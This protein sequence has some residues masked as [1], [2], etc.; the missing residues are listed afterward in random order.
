MKKGKTISTFFIIWSGQLLSIIGTSITNFGLGVWV[1]KLTGSVTQLALI[2]FSTTLPVLLLLPFSGSLVD[3][4]DRRTVMI[5][6][7]TV[8]G[9]S[10]LVIAILIFTNSFQ[11]WHIY[12]TT[13]ISSAASN[14]QSSAYSAS[15][16]LL[17]PK[18]QLG[19]ING[20]VQFSQALGYI[21]GPVLGALFLS[22][23]EIKGILI[24]DF[25]TFL[26]AVGAL[27]LVKIPL[28]FSI[29]ELKKKKQSLWMDAKEGIRYLLNKKG[30]IGLLGLYAALNFSGGIATVLMTPLVLSVADNMVLGSVMSVSGIGMVIGSVIMTAWGGPQRKMFGVLGFMAAIGLSIICFGIRPLVPLFF[31]AG[32]CAFFSIPIMNGCFTTLWQR[33]IAPEIQGR[34]F[35]LAGIVAVGTLPIAHLVAGPLADLIFEPALQTNGILAPSIGR[36]IGTGAGR[37]IGLMY[38]LLG[39]LSVIITCIGILTPRIRRLDLDLPDELKDDELP[40]EIE[41]KDIPIKE[42]A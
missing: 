16:P 11:I 28:P 23:I 36:I 18:K 38:I 29:E 15:I 34:A 31:C 14:F 9:I 17:V 7:D 41:K 40:E 19:R 39:L 42:N 5:V 12:I 24:I 37:G 30:L 25:A 6:G 20:I 32:F 3:R 33:K 10:T 22:L 26:F 1:Y 35:S 13:A 4:W 27:L 8:A 21:I 2:S